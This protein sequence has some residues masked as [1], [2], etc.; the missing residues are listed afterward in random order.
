VS[1][2][3]KLITQFKQKIE[4][5]E[6]APYGDGRFEVFA[7]GDKV[8]SKLKTGDFPKEGAVVK[9]IAAKL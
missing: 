7:G 6:L 4:G 5:L 3:T 9:A 1:L 8:Y 2:A